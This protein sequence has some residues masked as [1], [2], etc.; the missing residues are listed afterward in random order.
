MGYY[1]GNGARLVATIPSSQTLRQVQPSPLTDAATGLVDAGNWSV[2]ASWA[3]PATAT[4]GLYFARLTREDTGGASAAYFVVRDDD[5]ASDLLFQTADTTWQA[6]N[7]WGGKSLY[8]GDRSGGSRA[9]KVSYNRPLTIDSVG[10]G[11]GD[12]NSP[13]HAEYPMIRW[14]EA[15]GYNVSYFTDVD[16]DRIGGEIREHKVF[17]SVG[18]D[19]YWS[20]QQRA[21]VEAARDAGVNLAFFSGNEV[22]WK[23]RWENQ[24][25]RLGHAVPHPRLLQGVE[26]QRQDRPQ[27]RPGPAPGGTTASARRPTAAGRRTR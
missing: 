10:G 3:V 17:L 16:S 4:S 22:F 21:N 2:S 9:F 12:Y 14:L 27:P 1:Q 25:R 19:E 23:T 24:H 18:H 15:N 7:A 26:S 13:L 20:G 8:D 11:L 5:G 6:Y